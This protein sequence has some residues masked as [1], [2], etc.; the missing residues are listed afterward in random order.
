MR[1]DLAAAIRGIPATLAAESLTAS[2][3]VFEPLHDIAPFDDVRLTRDA[4]YGPHERNRL[5][6]FTRADGPA[7]KPVLVYVH[8]GAFVGGNKSTPGTPYYD[9]I[10]V[11]A[12][13]NG[14]VGVTTTYRLAPAHPW[15]AGTE[16]LRGTI[17]WLRAHIVEHGGDP[18][19]IVL[20]GQSAGATHVASYVAFAAHHAAPGGGIAA[21]VLM[22]GI[23][24]FVAYKEDTIVPYLGPDRTMYAERAPIGEIASTTIPVMFGCS[25]F[26]PPAFHAQAAALFD[27]FF[28]HTK[29][30][31]NFLYLPGHNHI[32]QVA[33]LGAAG[34]DDPLLAY[35]LREFIERA[36]R[37]AA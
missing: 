37:K 35:R 8:G 12:A 15:P 19:R 21:A 16:D 13:R 10:G 2:R 17:A 23:Y 11:W 28:A 6:I 34:A 9:N 25:E 3:K 36:G 7:A 31:P 24:D 20:M 18:E 33:H 22:S 1:P 26:D 4:A 27:A 5:D 32:S 14:F 29:R 30:I